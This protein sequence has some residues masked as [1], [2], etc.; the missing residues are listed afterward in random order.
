MRFTTVDTGFLIKLERSER[1]LA[2]LTR[3]CLEQGIESGV[4]SAIGAVKNTEIGYYALEKR[5]YFF[6]TILEDR[7]V[8]SMTGNIVLVDEQPFIHAHAVLAACDD[9][10]SCVGGHVKEAEVAVTLEVY[11]TPFS[12]SVSRAYDE[13]IGLKLLNL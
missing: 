5:A 2:S 3:F 6:R 9:S 8:A 4:F 11:L 1:V 12:E 10:L 7:E 13:A